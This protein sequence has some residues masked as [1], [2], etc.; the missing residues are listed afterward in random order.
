MSI[1]DKNENNLPVETVAWADIEKSGKFST[2]L[3]VQTL[4]RPMNCLSKF[5]ID[6]RD[7]DGNIS[8]R[9]LLGFKSQITGC[10]KNRA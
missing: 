5:S 1:A 9:N 10:F 2:G 3:I 4:L 6:H 8:E 7:A